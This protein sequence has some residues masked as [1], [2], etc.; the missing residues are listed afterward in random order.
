[1][2]DDAC[3]GF[4]VARCRFNKH[5]VSFEPFIESCD[6]DSGFFEDSSRLRT[7]RIVTSRNSHSAQ[8]ETAQLRGSCSIQARACSV[9]L[10]TPNTESSTLL[11][12]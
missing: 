3:C 6:V 4:D 9:N 2:P 7:L 10:S 5:C 11:S 8:R 1:M 12:T